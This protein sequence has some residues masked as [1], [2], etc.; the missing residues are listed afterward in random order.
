MQK[1]EITI[2]MIDTEK[3][4]EFIKLMKLHDMLNSDDILYEYI[5]GKKVPVNFKSIEF[6]VEYNSW[7]GE[8][9]DY[10]TVYISSNN[11]LICKRA[12]KAWRI[13]WEYR[14][15]N[16]LTIKRRKLINR[17]R[18]ITSTQYVNVEPYFNSFGNDILDEYEGEYAHE[19]KKELY[20]SW[21]KLLIGLKSTS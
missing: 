2:D 16:D 6:D 5:D 7:N 8:S 13:A 4:N 9:H 11:N 19:F 1:Y 12:R 17:L 15:K 14:F 21:I 3:L 10:R 18:H 20:Y